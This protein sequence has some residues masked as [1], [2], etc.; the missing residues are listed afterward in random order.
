LQWRAR[1]E[2]RKNLSRLAAAW[3]ERVSPALETLKARALAQ[4]EA[5]LAALE[6]SLARTGAD[7]PALRAALAEVEAV[8]AALEAAASGP[9]GPDPGGTAGGNRTR[10]RMLAASG[11]AGSGPG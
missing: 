7:A 5:E 4:A 3:R 10:A 1:Y 8:R 11:Q 2:V 9:A 6:Q